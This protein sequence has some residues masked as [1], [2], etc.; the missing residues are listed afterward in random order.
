MKKLRYLMYVLLAALVIFA[1]VTRASAFTLPGSTCPLA[2]LDKVKETQ[3]LRSIRKAGQT[4]SGDISN[5]P[6]VMIVVGFNNCPYSDEYDWTEKAFTNKYSIS[7]YYKDMS[8]GQFTFAPATET[9][10]YGKDGNTNVNDAE[11][12]GVIH[13]N[14]DLD[15]KN[16]G[17]LE[18]AFTVNKLQYYLKE[19]LEKAS[20]DIKISDYDVN[21]NGEIENTEL[22][23]SFVLAGY[24]ASRFEPDFADDL[25]KASVW[26][27]QYYLDTDPNKAPAF[28]GVKVDNY[29]VIAEK[30][31][32]TYKGLTSVGQE[33]L[34][35]LT[36]EL[37]HYLGLKDL[38]DSNVNYH[39]YNKKSMEW[40]SYEVGFFSP[41]DSA[42][43]VYNPEADAYLPVSLDAW[44]KCV[45][46]WVEPTIVRNSQTITLNSNS[47]GKYNIVMVENLSS[48]NM[49]EYYLLE[50]RV[51]NGWDSSLSSL[52]KDCNGGVIAWH[53]DKA[54]NDK[55]YYENRINDA[56]HRPCAMPLFLEKG[57]SGYFSDPISS[58]TV[59]EKRAPIYAK[60]YLTKWNLPLVPFVLYGTGDDADKRSA[61]KLSNSG[62]TVLSDPADSMEVEITM[63]SITPG[64]SSETLCF[65]QTVTIE[66]ESSSISDD[67][68]GAVTSSDT[69]VSDAEIADGKLV[70]TAKRKVGSVTLTV[71]SEKG[72][73]AMITVKVN[74]GTV[75]KLKKTKGK[76]RVKK[77]LKIVLKKGSY[78]GDKIYRCKSSNK[79][80]AKVTNA[81]KVTGKKKGKAV[82]TVTLTSGATKK[83][84]VTVV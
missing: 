12:D 30:E 9:S 64:A 41:M 49:N 11:N 26:P 5:I 72:A 22:A 31:H 71:V 36:H 35:A 83:F 27:H 78:A 69:S 52:F 15:H 75:A 48:S 33:N 84:K 47:S 16:W 1:P 6:L 10:K 56:D 17:D 2:T 37:G 62:F 57:P 25:W 21:K 23:I 18:V 68:F 58:W 63:P 39:D 65:G 74:K 28:D 60:N 53:I 44:S 73:T 55:Y 29:V 45:L 14:L 50:N 34:G 59:D 38:Y 32:E 19:A 51:F 3:K 20:S 66:K 46:G 80:I 13:V 81:G 8:Y 76:V 7:S 40:G 42:I 61:R 82:I 24:D 70:V 54:V 77:S 43:E 79:K 4:I 67:A